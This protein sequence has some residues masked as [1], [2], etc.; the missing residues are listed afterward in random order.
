MK[1]LI[2]GFPGTG[3]S[4]V[5]QELQRRGHSAYDTEAMRGYMHLED[6]VTG[7]RVKLPDPVPRGWF[8]TRGNFNWDIV[9]VTQ[10]LEAHTDDVFICALADNQGALYD[11][12]DKMFILIVDEVDLEKRLRLRTTTDYGKDGLEMADIMMLHKHFEQSL[13]NLGAIPINAKKALHDVVDDI[14]KHVE[15]DQQ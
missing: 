4:S 5:A 8:D 3:K 11:Q 14:L 1:V 6:V 7:E 10:L 9:R 15:Y 2:T 13:Q 12:F